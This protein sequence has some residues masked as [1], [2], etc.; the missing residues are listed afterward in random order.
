MVKSLSFVFLS[1]ASLAITN[2][3]KQEYEFLFVD[4]Y[5]SWCSHCKQL[6]PTWEVLAET[7]VETAVVHLESSY[8]HQEGGHD[9]SEEEFKEALKVHIPVTIAKVDCVVHK[10]LCS[11]NQIWAYPTLRLF[12]NGDFYAD[13]MGDRTVV[14]MT[15]WLAEQEEFVKN[16]EED[17]EHKIA[18]A[19][20]SKSVQKEFTG[21]TLFI[22]CHSFT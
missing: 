10:D 19:D 20:E 12:V 5:A 4:F 14:E 21:K 13:Y 1:H 2:V 17:P 18:V 22:D 8:E 15:H 9:Y 3:A 11:E 16:W 6:A 7:M